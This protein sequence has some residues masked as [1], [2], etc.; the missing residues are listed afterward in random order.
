[1]GAP[2]SMATGGNDV[3]SLK[4]LIAG[5]VSIRLLILFVRR[6]S[7]GDPHAL[8]SPSPCWLS[9]SPRGAAILAS[10]G[11]AVVFGLTSSSRNPFQAD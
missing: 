11:H 9:P 1:M 6:I 2:F 8:P 7:L 5:G 3:P 4:W 10:F